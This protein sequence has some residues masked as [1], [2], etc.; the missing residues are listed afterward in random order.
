MVHTMCYVFC[1]DLGTN[2]DFYFIYHYVIGF[3]I[4]GGECL[5]CTMHIEVL[6]KIDYVSPLK[7]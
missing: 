4:T 5:L 6:H 2:S 7:G 3:V 1:T